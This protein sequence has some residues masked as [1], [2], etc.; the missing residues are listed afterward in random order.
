MSNVFRFEAEPSMKAKEG[1]AWII[2]YLGSTGIIYKE[3]DNFISAFINGIGIE[4]IAG[5]GNSQTYIDVALEVY[6]VK[7][8]QIE[9]RFTIDMDFYETTMPNA[10]KLAFQFLREYEGDAV[11]SSGDADHCYF[12]RRNGQLIID[13]N[14]GILEQ[15]PDLVQV[16]PTPYTVDSL[17]L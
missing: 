1:L 15:F 12:L 14:Y 13:D 16:V 7:P 4:I 11:F 17:R 6:N 10:L 8:P 2:T 3:E 5:I 9:I